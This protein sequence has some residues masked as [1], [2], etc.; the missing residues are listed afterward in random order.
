MLIDSHELGV[1][2]LVLVTPP[3]CCHCKL[4]VPHGI[5]TME[6][7]YGRNTGILSPGCHCCYPSYKRI[8]GMVSKNSIRFDAPVTLNQ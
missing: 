7:T 2:V 8:S 6:Q 3:S 1:P 4:N 5:V